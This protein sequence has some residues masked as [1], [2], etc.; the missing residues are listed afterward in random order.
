MS[1]LKIGDK[2]VVK[3]SGRIYPHYTE[4]FQK[5]GFTSKI[6]DAEDGAIGIIFATSKHPIS[7]EPLA[8]V[9][10]KSGGQILIDIDA[11]R[12]TKRSIVSDFIFKNKQ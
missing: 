8:A 9:D 1:T 5:L 4:M 6:N 12:K 3:N 11:I 10:M 7:N 2:V